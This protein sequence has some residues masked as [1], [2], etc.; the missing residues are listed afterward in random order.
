MKLLH[1]LITHIYRARRIAQEQEA[2]SQ[3]TVAMAQ[4]AE[5]LST[6]AL[7][8]AKNARNTLRETQ[9]KHLECFCTC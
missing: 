5:D 8:T 9:V 7:D 6:S 1:H 4:E 2:K 3:E